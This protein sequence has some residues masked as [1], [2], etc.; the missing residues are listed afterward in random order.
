MSTRDALREQ[1][2]LVFLLKKDADPRRVPTGRKPLPCTLYCL[3]QYGRQVDH[4]SYCGDLWDSAASICGQNIMEYR[5]GHQ[6]RPEYT[7]DYPREI[8]DL[9]WQ[10]R[11]R[12]CPYWDDEPWPNASGDGDEEPSECVCQQ[13][14]SNHT[15]DEDSSERSEGGSLDEEAASEELT[16]E[17]ESVAEE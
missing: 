14:G 17:D 12:E 8:F 11:E 16:E 10:G 7:A 2:V 6:R 4:G 1:E 9:L 3:G 15:D 13:V 5:A